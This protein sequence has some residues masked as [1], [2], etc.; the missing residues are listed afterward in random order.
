M[1]VSPVVYSAI[2]PLY[3]EHATFRHVA[4]LQGE[5]VLRAYATRFLFTLRPAWLPACAMRFLARVCTAR[6]RHQV[7]VI[8]RSPSLQRRRTTL[9]VKHFAQDQNPVPLR[10]VTQSYVETVAAPSWRVSTTEAQLD[11]RSIPSRTC[12][13]QSCHCAGSEWRSQ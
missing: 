2:A 7:R 6:L 5:V 8:F 13:S 10:T 11:L 1:N 3:C 4:F 9:D 12:E